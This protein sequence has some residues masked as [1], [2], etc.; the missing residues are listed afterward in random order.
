[1]GFVYVLYNECF[2]HYGTGVYKL[3]M[4][5]DPQKRL[6]QY[7]TSYIHP[8]E[9]L[10]LHETDNALEIEQ[11]VFKELKSK[12]ISSKREFFR[13]SLD[14][15]KAAIDRAHTFAKNKLQWKRSPQRKMLTKIKSAEFHMEHIMDDS[16]GQEKFYIKLAF[17]INHITKEFY[18]AH[19]ANRGFVAFNNLK[20]FLET[21]DTI[22]ALFIGSSENSVV[23]KLTEARMLING[24]MK[25][26]KASHG[27]ALG[28]FT[29]QVK[30]NDVDLTSEEM[31]WIDAHYQE[32]QICFP[33]YGRIRSGEKDRSSMCDLLQR[34]LKKHLGF[35]V[36][37]QSK[38]VKVRGEYSH[39]IYTYTIENLDEMVELL[40][41]ASERGSFSKELK[42][43][44]EAYCKEN[45][46][47]DTKWH[48]LKGNPPME[49]EE[50][51][52]RLIQGEMF[53][54]DDL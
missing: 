38:M 13:C 29:M 26:C 43:N 2:E 24:L 27:N 37:K 7:T 22:A 41:Y 19:V 10:L 15:V 42:E 23:A 18:D 5:N 44:L 40:A 16:Q 30:T 1:M 20:M 9:Y 54:D 14:D 31:Q 48:E 50:L 36:R 45:A 39:R 17:G 28:G 33:N 32:I 11:R 47:T 52:G 8:S 49:F 53:I 35:H 3:G 51:S 34:I 4:T 12:R 6:G 46:A 21:D 25:I